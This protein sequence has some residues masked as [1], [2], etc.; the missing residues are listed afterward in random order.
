MYTFGSVKVGMVCAIHEGIRC[1]K[2]L[3]D[4]VFMWDP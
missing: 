2:V 3:M 4:G 1:T